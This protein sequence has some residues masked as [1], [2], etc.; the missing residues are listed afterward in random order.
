MGDPVAAC[1][2]AVETLKPEGSVMLVEPMAG[3][4]PVG[5]FNPVGRVYT[6]ASVLC[7][8]PN[9]LA[10]GPMALG[11]V[12]SDDELRKVAMAGG[13]ANF[14]RATETPFNR[15]FQAKVN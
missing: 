7:C 12:A 1:K 4:A 9:A 13:L 2:R 11:T 8:T 5:N 14:R 6:A 15:V 10:S 3:T